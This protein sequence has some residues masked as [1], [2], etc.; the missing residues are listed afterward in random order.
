M[1]W[2]SPFGW[3]TEMRSYV[4]ERWW[5]LLLSVGA[6]GGLVAI[7]VAIGARRDVGAG[8]ITQRPAP[9]TASPRLGTSLGLALRLQ[10]ASLISWSVPLFLLSLVYGGIAQEAGEF[11][12]DVDL[13]EYLTRIG[14]AEAADQY[15]ALTLFISVLI[16]AGFSIQ[17]VLRMRTEESSLRAEPLLATPLSRGRWFGGHLAMAMGGSFVLL[18]MIGLGTG[19]A[20]AMSADDIGELPRLIG[21]ALAYTPGLWVFSGLAAALFGL[22]P[23]AVGVAWGVFGVLV[24][25][26]FIGPILQ[27][28]NWVYELSPV[29][30]VPRL[31]VA[32]FSVAPVLALAAIAAALI[33]AGLL[34]FRHRD[35]LAA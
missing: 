5:P 31:P 3:A 19:I 32:D 14:A 8:I 27:L 33:A 23:R 7:A 22:V 17:A 26:G 13:S 9:A 4:D 30:Q 16:A 21:A 25:I 29:E 34:G 28:P 20:R 24:F 1:S 12:E 11:Y 10:R 15:L 2:L 18:L 6:T 35:I